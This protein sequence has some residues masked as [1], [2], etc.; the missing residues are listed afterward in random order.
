MSTGL[1]AAILAATV[2]LSIFQAAAQPNFKTGYSQIGNRSG[3]A[4]IT[5]QK[6]ITIAQ[7]NFS[8][9]V[10]TINHLENAFRV[11]MLSRHGTVHIIMINDEDGVIISSH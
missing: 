3:P 11:K 4:N 5:E 1:K 8:G 2:M 7:Q 9:R 10:L 6:A